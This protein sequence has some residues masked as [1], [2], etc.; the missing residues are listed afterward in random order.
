MRFS[1]T[2]MKNILAML[3]N[4][5]NL[6]HSRVRFSHSFTDHDSQRYCK[7]PIQ[8]P[9]RFFNVFIPQSL[10]I[11]PSIILNKFIRTEWEWTID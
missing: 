8:F 5:V 2:R 4:C 3:L 9:H 7:K 1:N 6:I 10:I 11:R